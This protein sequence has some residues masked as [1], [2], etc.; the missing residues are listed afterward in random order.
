MHLQDASNYYAVRIKSNCRDYQVLRFTAGNPFVLLKG[1]AREPF[2]P[3]TA[4]TFTVKSAAPF[5]F[6][7]S[8]TRAGDP[9]VLNSNRIAQDFSQ[10]FSGGYAGLYC[11]SASPSDPDA[12]FDNVH[13]VIEPC[14]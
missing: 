10:V 7:I 1:Y 14:K 3:G 11:G 4:Y 13:L 9:N 5:I 8:I 12:V 6:D 2:I